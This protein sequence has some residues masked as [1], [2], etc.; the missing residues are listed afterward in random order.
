[1]AVKLFLKMKQDT[2]TV[3][4][5]ND[6]DLISLC[7]LLSRSRTMCNMRHCRSWNG[8]SE[9]QSEIKDNMTF[10]KEEKLILQKAVI[11]VFSLLLKNK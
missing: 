10:D 1:M 8:M 5:T 7:S 2:K 11:L 4:I 6:K 9:K 3:I